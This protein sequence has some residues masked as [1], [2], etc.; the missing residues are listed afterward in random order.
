MVLGKGEKSTS[1]SQYDKS[2]WYES[3]WGRGS[4][5]AGVPEL[6]SV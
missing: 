4:G 6:G 1:A 3:G 2:L 5:V